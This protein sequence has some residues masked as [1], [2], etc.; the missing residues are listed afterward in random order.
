MRTKILAL[1][2]SVI[3]L[4]MPAVAAADQI[5]QPGDTL[6][7]I[8]ENDTMSLSQIESDNP[9]IANYDLIYPGELIHTDSELA[10]PAVAAPVP[11]ETSAS[12]GSYLTQ[13]F[14]HESGN[15]PYA[16]NPYS[17]A[18]GL[19]QALPCSKLLSACGSLSNVGCQ[20]DFFT[21]YA[22]RA[23]GSTANAWN[24]WQSRRWW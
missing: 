8:A 23:Y 20:I 10:S 5:V 6:S 19:G 17:G 4:I 11:V 24:V 18:C 22:V 21:A 16:V 12:A 7:G 15:N 2:A 14:N 13:I 1:A 9:Q 3:I